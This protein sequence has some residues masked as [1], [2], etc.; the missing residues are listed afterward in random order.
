MKARTR[1]NQDGSINRIIEGSNGD[2]AVD[3]FPYKIQNR[4]LFYDRNHPL[5]ISPE[6]FEYELYWGEKLKNY[7]EGRWVYDIDTWVFMPPKLDFYIN[8]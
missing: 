4:D 1:Y 7:L 8:Y 3:L 6:S 2:F 5:N